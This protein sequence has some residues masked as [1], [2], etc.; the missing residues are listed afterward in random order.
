MGVRLVMPRQC[1]CHLLAGRR[2]ASGDGE[3]FPDR[4]GGCGEL[5]F[6]GGRPAELDQW[7]FGWKAP[8]GLKTLPGCTL[9]IGGGE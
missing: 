6:G 7:I 2:V 8:N 4:F 3:Q 9:P 5:I 1:A